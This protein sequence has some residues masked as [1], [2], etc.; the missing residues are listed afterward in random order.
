ELIRTLKF[1]LF[2]ISAGVIQIASFTLL[3]EF[4]PLSYW[5][6]YL[7]S[8]VLSVL[9]NFTINRKFT[10]HSAANVPIAM[11]KVFLYY[12]AFTPLSTIGGNYLVESLHWNEYLVEI[13]SMLLNFITEFLF[14]R[15]VVYG[16]QVDNDEKYIEKESKR[17]I[18]NLKESADELNE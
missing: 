18:K 8:L 17:S 4:T 13:L 12:C 16:K 14:T 6:C 3:T 10:F 1:V 11:L 2:S 7:I 9:Y 15:F 5:P